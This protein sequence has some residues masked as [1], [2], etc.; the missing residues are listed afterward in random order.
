[1]PLHPLVTA[2]QAWAQAHRRGLAWG[3]SLGLT[4]LAATAFGLAPLAPSATDLPQRMVTQTL[5]P[6]VNLGD[7]L[8]ALSDVPLE[9]YRSDTTRKQDTAETL[10]GRL[11]VNDAQAAAFIRQDRQAR[12]LLEGRAQKMVRAKADASGRLIEL[13]ARYPAEQRNLADTH[14]LRLTLKRVDDAWVTDLE[15]V[16]LQSR[17]QLGSG[18]IRSSL[19]AATDEAQMPDA[20]ASQMAEIFS[21]DIDFHRELKRGDSF[22]V[23]YESLTADGEPINWNQAAGRVLAAEFI[24]NGRVHQAVWF[25]DAQRGSYY[26]FSGKSK[27]RAFLASPMEFSRVTSGFAMRFHPIHQRVMAHT[28]VDYGAPVGTPTRSVADGTVEFA[29]WQ[30]GYGNTVIVRH[31]GDKTT[32]YAHLSRIDVR[33][34]ERVQQGQRIGAVGATGTATGP[35]LHFEFR[36]SG[37]HVDPLKA[38]RNAAPIPLAEPSRGAFMAQAQVLRTKLDVA[39]T[40][41]GDSGRGD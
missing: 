18:T 13:V 19:F 17:V 29:G 35:H 7:Q 37:R 8:E 2:V 26:D 23:V 31:G 22:S 10:L 16:E 28:G 40:L 38:A 39:A 27:R 34:G 1:M 9:L 5:L 24:N 6:A 20:I 15:T 41:V 30:G 12:K 32:L 21:G 25:K 4:G 3:F 36:V 14:F 33:R 11:G